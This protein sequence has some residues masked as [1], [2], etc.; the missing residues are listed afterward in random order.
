MV[1]LE[2]KEEMDHLQAY[3]RKL[4]ANILPNHVAEYFLKRERNVD[5]SEADHLLSIRKPKYLQ[6]QILF[7]I[8][9]LTFC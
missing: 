8:K 2:E 1:I 6:L 9:Q 7:F 4:V 3:N 5:V